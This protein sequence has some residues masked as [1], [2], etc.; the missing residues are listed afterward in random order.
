MK[1]ATL[2]DLLLNLLIVFPLSRDNSEHDPI[3]SDFIDWNHLSFLN[4]NVAKTTELCID[5]KKI[6]LVIPPVVVQGVELVQQYK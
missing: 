1:G 5:F 4:K 2:S 6:P 3:V